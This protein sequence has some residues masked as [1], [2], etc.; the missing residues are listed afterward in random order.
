[1]SEEEMTARYKG[2][3][4]LVLPLYE[5]GTTWIGTIGRCKWAREFYKGNY[6]WWFQVFDR[7][8]NWRF[9]C[10]DEIQVD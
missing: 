5:G 10:Q 9:L 6:Q 2:K 4:C 3:R 1:M 7:T 8:G